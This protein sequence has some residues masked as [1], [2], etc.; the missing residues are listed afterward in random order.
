[1]IINELL[2]L[3][4]MAKKKALWGA[5]KEREL[6]LNNRSVEMITLAATARQTALRP[7]RQCR[8]ALPASPASP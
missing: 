4:V 8:A 1:V 2:T 6:A 7:G 5:F 3:T